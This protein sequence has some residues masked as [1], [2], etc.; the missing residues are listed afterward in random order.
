MKSEK[1]TCCVAIA[2][3]RLITM[4]QWDGSAFLSPGQRG[5]SVSER[6]KGMAF[7]EGTDTEG[8]TPTAT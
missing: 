1:T 3:G 4:S 7:T 6:G 8:T 5:L 2:R